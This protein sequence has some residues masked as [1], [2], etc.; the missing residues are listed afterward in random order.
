MALFVCIHSSHFRN[1][2]PDEIDSLEIELSSSRFECFQKQQARQ[3]QDHSF[4]PLLL[5]YT[6]SSLFEFVTPGRGSVKTIHPGSRKNR[7]NM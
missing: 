1:L 5:L 2:T 3:T 4:M 7:K 6:T